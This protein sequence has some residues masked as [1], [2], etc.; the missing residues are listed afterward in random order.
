M[1]ILVPPIAFLEVAGRPRLT[2]DQ[3]KRSQ[4]VSAQSR[5]SRTSCDNVVTP[6]THG[7]PEARG[8][9]ETDHDVVET[10]RRHALLNS[11]RATSS[12]PDT[13]AGRRTSLPA[14][15]GVDSTD[16]LLHSLS[17]GLDR[18]RQ[19][20]VVESFQPACVYRRPVGQGIHR[21]W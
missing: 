11:L 8:T 13:A 15:R 21:R 18:L 14:G 9:R 2:A 6:S 16:E 10:P 7:L 3:G 19:I 4:Y 20:E 1:R 12:R 5:A 17:G